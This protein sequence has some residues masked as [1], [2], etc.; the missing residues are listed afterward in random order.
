MEDFKN[1]CLLNIEGLKE[2]ISNK[3]DWLD[4]FFGTVLRKYPTD[5]IQ[6]VSDTSAYIE[7]N[8]APKFNNKKER[9]PEDTKEVADEES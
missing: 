6:K 9:L 2:L 7:S 3:S 5:I 8:T 4:N 1:V